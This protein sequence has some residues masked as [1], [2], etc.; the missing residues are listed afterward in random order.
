[1]GATLSVALAVVAGALGGVAYSHAEPPLPL[2]DVLPPPESFAQAAGMSRFVLTRQAEDDLFEI[3]DYLA[4][5]DIDAADRM[6]DRSSAALPEG[7]LMQLF[8]HALG[9]QRQLATIGTR[10]VGNDLAL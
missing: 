5:S 4:Q 9:F 8:A 3:W 1:M 10:T 6:R 2:L 7:M